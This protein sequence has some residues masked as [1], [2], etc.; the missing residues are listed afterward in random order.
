LLVGDRTVQ[1]RRE[2]AP[3]SLQRRAESLLD[4]WNSQSAVTGTDI[5]A[6]DI[7]SREFATARQRILQLQTALRDIENEAQASG[8]PWTPGRLLN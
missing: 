2:A 4:N 3:W 1:S 8:L 7:A 6:Y 5:K